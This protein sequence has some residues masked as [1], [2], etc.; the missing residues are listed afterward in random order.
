M[1]YP[2]KKKNCPTPHADRPVS[3]VNRPSVVNQTNL[4]VPD[5]VK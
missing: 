3:Y 1:N 4:R 5:L 2:K